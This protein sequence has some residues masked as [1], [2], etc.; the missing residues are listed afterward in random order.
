M[1]IPESAAPGT[2]RINR[3]TKTIA[4]A[5][6]VVFGLSGFGHGFFEMLQG[7]TPTGGLMIN[8]IGDAHLFW[9][10]G[11]EPA[12]TLIPNF[13]IAGITTMLVSIAA[14]VWSAGFLHRKRGPLVFM[15]L[16][17][18]LLFVGGGVAQV[19]FFPVFWVLAARIR[20]PLSRKR[21]M[22]SFGRGLDRLW[23]PL[24]IA[25]AICILYTLQIAVF[26]YVPGVT[27]PDAVSVVMV[28]MLGAGYLLLILACAAG[29]AH[30]IG[31]ETHNE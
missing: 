18:L 30:D 9:A 8:A 29:F 7:H 3:A 31:K 24:I 19:I 15:L 28:S 14:I 17:L 16:F 2:P 10:Q 4:A 5:M 26:G 27:D 1:S 13:L 25:S 22:V 23:R 12:F 6:G 20:T 21:R 11:H